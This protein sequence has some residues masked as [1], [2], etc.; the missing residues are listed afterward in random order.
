VLAVDI[1]EAKRIA[2]LEN[3]ADLFIDPTQENFAEAALAWTNGEGLEAVLELTGAATLPSTMQA[4]GKG[5]RVVI[6]GHHTGN[7]LALQP[8]QMIANEWEIFGSRNVSK[9]ELVEVVSLVER[10]RIHPVVTGSYSLEE[11]EEVHA[12]LRAQE[13]VGRVVLEMGG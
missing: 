9:Q 10:G 13:I 12:R 3:G 11:A 5:G 8:S 7:E 6:I 1:G 2:A 4:L